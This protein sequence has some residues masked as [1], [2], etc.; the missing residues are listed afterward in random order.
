M[1]HV[2]K[3]SHARSVITCPGHD[4]ERNSGDAWSIHSLTYLQIEECASLGYV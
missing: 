3:L 4:T 1:R 2:A